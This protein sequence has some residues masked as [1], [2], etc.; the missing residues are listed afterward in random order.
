MNRLPLLRG[1]IDQRLSN[2]PI[3]HK[4]WIGQS[5]RF[6]ISKTGDGSETN[7]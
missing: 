4:R 1:R 5:A 2:V 6:G 3:L 7:R